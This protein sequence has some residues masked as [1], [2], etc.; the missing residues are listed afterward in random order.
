MLDQVWQ[1]SW[2]GASRTLDTHMASL[3]AKL[4]EHARITTVRGVGYRL[5][6]TGAGPVRG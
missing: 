4:D 3:R 1:S 5:E 6:T 2:E